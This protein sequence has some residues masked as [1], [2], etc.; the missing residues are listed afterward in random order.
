VTTKCKHCQGP[1]DRPHV[2]DKCTWCL[3]IETAKE[4]AGRDRGEE[5]T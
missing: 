1:V 4:L 3:A 5:S 2:A